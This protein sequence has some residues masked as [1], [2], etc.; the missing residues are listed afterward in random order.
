MPRAWRSFLAAIDQASPSPIELHCVDGFPVTTY[1]GL[2]RR[3]SDAETFQVIPNHGAPWLA[4]LAGRQGT[5]YKSHKLYLQIGRVAMLPFNYAGRLREVFEREFARLRLFV[6]DP[7]DLALSRLH[8]DPAGGF[9]D[10]MSL[11]RWN[12]V[13]LDRIEERYRLEVR[14]DLSGPVRAFDDRLKWWIEKARLERGSGV[15]P[16]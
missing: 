16:A 7:V 3:E 10:F 9:D 4:A 14:P 13:D 8:A 6:P 12:N 1:Y 11:V 15:K 2:A 5:L